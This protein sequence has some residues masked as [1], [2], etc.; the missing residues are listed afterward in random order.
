MIKMQSDSYCTVRKLRPETTPF[1]IVYPT[2]NLRSKSVECIHCF[3]KS[4]ASHVDIGSENGSS[5]R[6]RKSHFDH[7]V[8]FPNLLN[9]EGRFHFFG[10]RQLVRE[11]LHCEGK[12]TKMPDNT[13]NQAEMERPIS[14]AGVGGRGHCTDGLIVW[15][16]WQ[17]GRTLLHPGVLVRPPSPGGEAGRRGDVAR[18]RGGEQLGAGPVHATRAVCAT[19][20]RAISEHGVCQRSWIFLPGVMIPLNCERRMSESEK[21]AMS[22][23]GRGFVRFPL[24][25]ADQRPWANYEAG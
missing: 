25:S 4:S 11:F 20:P 1:Q 5:I 6:Y 2:V 14:E 7:V 24:E 9:I 15:R 21:V 16:Y 3:G 22:A 18:G 13:P 23:S 8:V 17:P 10:E 12:A 19:H